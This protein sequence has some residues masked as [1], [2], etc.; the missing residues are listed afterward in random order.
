MEGETSIGTKETR[1]SRANEAELEVDGNNSA[2]FALGFVA[3][4][5]THDVF[6]VT[7]QIPVILLCLSRVR[8]SGLFQIRIS[9][10]NKE[11]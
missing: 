8:P 3:L 10:G 9:S 4:K 11:A 7:K 2:A 1:K 6:L 5:Q